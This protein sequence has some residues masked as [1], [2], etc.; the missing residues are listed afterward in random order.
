M[1]IK[2]SIEGDG[3]EIVSILH[4]L[5]AGG[6]TLPQLGNALLV[7]ET[8]PVEGD[9]LLDPFPPG[10]DGASQPSPSEATVRAGCDV[11]YGIIH[12]WAEG[13][14]EEGVDQP[15]RGHAILSA[16]TTNS[17]DVFAFLRYC[18]GLTRLVRT[19][20]PDWPVVRA[21]LI[22]ENIASVC[23]ALGIPGIADHL[24]YTKE[25]TREALGT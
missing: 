23:G 9:D 15:D 20:R 21:R 2:L 3:A 19:I 22:A 5:R 14:G 6:G 25:Y 11:W 17:A 1:P 24:E 13:F 12:T 18:D 8:S 7:P 16:M 10:D 4:A